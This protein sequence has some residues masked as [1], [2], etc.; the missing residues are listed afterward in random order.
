MKISDFILGAT[1]ICFPI[2]LSLMAVEGAAKIVFALQPTLTA[3]IRPITVAEQQAGL[4]CGRAAVFVIKV[5]GGVTR[6]YGT[7]VPLN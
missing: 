4:G 6:L 3:F 2:C 7:A 5:A 1:E